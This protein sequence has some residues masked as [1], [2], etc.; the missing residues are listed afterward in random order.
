MQMNSSTVVGESLL[1][2]ANFGLQYRGHYVT[3]KKLYNNEV[4]HILLQCIRIESQK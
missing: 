3:D 1:N 4:I 2:Y